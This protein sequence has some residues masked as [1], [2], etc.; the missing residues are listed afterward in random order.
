MRIIRC[1]RLDGFMQTDRSTRILNMHSSHSPGSPDE[2]NQ[3]RLE[4]LVLCTVQPGDKQRTPPNISV[5]K[6]GCVLSQELRW[7]GAWPEVAFPPSST[8]CY[9]PF[10]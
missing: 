9:T 3:L 7:L 5:Y 10:M 4:R 2:R 6:T 8:W 1:C